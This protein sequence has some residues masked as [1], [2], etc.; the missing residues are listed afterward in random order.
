M[1]NCI[2]WTQYILKIHIQVPQVHDS[3]IIY[4]STLWY[5]ETECVPWSNKAYR[6][7]PSSMAFARMP[8]CLVIKLVSFLHARLCQGFVRHRI[9]ITIQSWMSADGNYVSVTETLL[10]RGEIGFIFS[11][12]P[13]QFLWWQEYMTSDI[14][15][16]RA[17]VLRRV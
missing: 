2:C 16:R 17:I 6:I 1:H 13:L 5:F 9:Y 4:K 15:I 10:C 14:L 11:W 7:R 8:K 12:R 3:S